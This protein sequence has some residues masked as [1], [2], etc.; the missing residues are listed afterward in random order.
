MY[1]LTFIQCILSVIAML[2][3]GN[4]EENKHGLCPHE[5]YSLA[6]IH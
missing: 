4:K 3:H 5:A 1:Q 6:I 2:S